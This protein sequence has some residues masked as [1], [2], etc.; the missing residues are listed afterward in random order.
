MND[1]NPIHLGVP[2]VFE[3]NY[4]FDTD[5][6]INRAL[7]YSSNTPHFKSG[8]DDVLEIGN[9]GTT[10]LDKRVGPHTWPEF[11]DFNQWVGY[12]AS[13]IFECWRY[14]VDSIAI[15]SSWF[16]QHKKGGWTNFHLHPGAHLVMAA[17]VSAPPGSGDLKIID[18]LEHHW[19]GFPTSINE[20]NTQGIS[21]K[22]ETN[23][24]VFFAPFLR[25]GTGINQTDH[26]RWVISMNIVCFSKNHVS[27]V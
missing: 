13:K 25:H 26:D 7:Q 27:Q 15:T 18:P 14:D 1:L 10:A 20:D 16:N 5:A 22:A 3:S 11:E 8:M 24:V 17:Y 21:I 6:V 12:Q 9:A 4:K 19:S 2:L 23:K